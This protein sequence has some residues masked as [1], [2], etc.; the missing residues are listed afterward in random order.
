MSKS[1][2]RSEADPSFEPQTNQCLDLNQALI[3]QPHSTF[4]FGV[5][6]DQ[7]TDAGI[8]PEDLLVVERTGEAQHG[9]IVIVCVGE[10]LSVKRY[11]VSDDGEVWFASANPC[12]LPMNAAECGAFVWGKVT[13]SIQAHSGSRWLVGSDESAEIASADEWPDIIDDEEEVH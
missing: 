5:T 12:Y 8:N 2:K 7:M 3:K 4:Y 6:G 1:K 13:F 9:D 10:E 11:E